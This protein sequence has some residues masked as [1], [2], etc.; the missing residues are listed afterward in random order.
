MDVVPA[1]LPGRQDAPF[2][3]VFMT[4][5]PT[6]LYRDPA[7]VAPPIKN[8]FSSILGE[9][10]GAISHVLFA[11]SPAG[12]KGCGGLIFRAAIFIDAGAIWTARPASEPDAARQ[13][14]AERARGP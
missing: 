1:A 11:R 6:A 2:P 7:T 14:P 12:R 4:A 8:L 9:F 10:G 5:I 13:R 3:Y